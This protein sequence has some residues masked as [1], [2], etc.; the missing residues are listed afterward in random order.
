M[1]NQSLVLASASPR[2]R[3]LLDLMS[4]AFSAHSADIDESVLEGEAPAAYVAR[5]AG[6]KAS[7]VW[8]L[9]KPDKNLSRTFILG[10]DT[11][12]V[13]DGDILGKPDDY[14]DART[15][16][17]RLSRRWHQVYTGIYVLTAACRSNGAATSSGLHDR[18]LRVVESRVKFREV[19]DDEIAWYWQSGEPRDKAG[20]YAV[21]GAG[22]LFIER[23][24]GS[25]SGI[26]G[27]PLCETAE[28]LRDAG[29]SGGPL[30][31]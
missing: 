4:V 12:V 13:V 16:L 2:R 23:I 31:L 10:A 19:G 5:L 3:Q 15:M 28:L 14:D 17:R 25:Y 1:P 6:A 24:E 30:S 7:A 29:F 27:L 26:V 21:Q 8:D 9:I 11:A 20:A 18:N 22:G